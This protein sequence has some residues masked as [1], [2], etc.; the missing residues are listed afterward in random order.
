MLIGSGLVSV[1]IGLLW[2]LGDYHVTG[3]GAW[4]AAFV[5]LANDGARAFV[6]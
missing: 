5:L 4:T 1:C 3:F 6:E 2:M